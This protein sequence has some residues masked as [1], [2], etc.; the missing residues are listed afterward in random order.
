MPVI[1]C[2]EECKIATF[3]GSFGAQFPIE[4]MAQA[5]ASSAQHVDVAACSKSFT[6]DK[7]QLVWEKEQRHRN[8]IDDAVKFL[9][10]T[11]A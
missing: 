10:T 11:V 8:V 2:P 4:E 9:D 1:S 3:D 6:D 7:K 5:G